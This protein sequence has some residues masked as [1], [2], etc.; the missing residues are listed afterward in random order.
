ITDRVNIR[1]NTGGATRVELR[2]PGGLGTGV[3]GFRILAGGT[4][5]R[6]LVINGFPSDGIRIEA[7]NVA[8]MDSFIGTEADGVT[9]RPN[10]M[11]GV[12]VVWPSGPSNAVIGG[13]GA[14]EANVIAFNRYAGVVAWFGT[15][16]VIRGNSIHD[17][18]GL[19]IDHGDGGNLELTPPVIT[20]ADLVIKGTS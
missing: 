5:I 19:G 4:T 9:P 13:T 15:G 17:N 7:P 8:V 3:F 1:G 6:S 2:G 18:T 12:I 14:G 11:N 10:N 16:N 20:S